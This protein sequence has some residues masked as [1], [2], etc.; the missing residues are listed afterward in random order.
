[1]CSIGFFL[2]S[3]SVDWERCDA[4]LV[5]FAGTIFWSKNKNIIKKNNNGVIDEQL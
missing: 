5:L 1:M 2:I 3:S 4:L